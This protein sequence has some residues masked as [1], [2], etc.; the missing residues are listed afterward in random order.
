MKQSRDGSFT[1]FVNGFGQCTYFAPMTVIN[2]FIQVNCNLLISYK[3]LITSMKIRQITVFFY[4]FTE[5]H[6]IS[7]YQH[8]Q[9]FTFHCIY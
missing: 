1:S 9:N 6:K 3:T 4:I 7:P 8:K 5:Q 2:L